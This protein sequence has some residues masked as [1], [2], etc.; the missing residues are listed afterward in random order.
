[1]LCVSLVVDAEG[2]SGYRI[3]ARRLMLLL[4]PAASF[5]EVAEAVWTSGRRAVVR[6]RLLAPKLLLESATGSNSVGAGTHASGAQLWSYG[7]RQFLP[8]L[9]P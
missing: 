4:Y 1:M 3:E 9:T 6:V 7:S 2:R 5:T 8:L